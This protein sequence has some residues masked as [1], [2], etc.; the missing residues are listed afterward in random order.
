MYMHTHVHTH[1]HTNTC[2]Q[3]EHILLKFYTCN[4]ACIKVISRNQASFCHTTY[5][6][7]SALGPFI[8]LVYVND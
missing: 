5:L 8:F 1:I 6:Q 7:G 3:N 2:K 4:D